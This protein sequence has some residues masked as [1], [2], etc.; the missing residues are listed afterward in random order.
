MNG[1]L[2]FD[3]AVAT[4]VRQTLD[5]NI[6]ISY[7]SQA[8]EWAH[9]QFTIVLMISIHTERQCHIYSIQIQ[10][11]WQFLRRFTTTVS[12]CAVHSAMRAYVCA[13]HIFNL[14]TSKL[15]VILFETKKKKKWNAWFH[16]PSFSLA[17]KLF[18]WQAH[19]LI[20]TN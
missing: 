1:S 14:F 20:N 19:K 6:K 8:S 2:C 7:K 18:S 10:W 17:I 12:A 9:A 13:P 16:L 4:I 5:Q 3:V 15:F 11:N